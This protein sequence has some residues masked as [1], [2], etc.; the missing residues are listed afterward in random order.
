MVYKLRSK[1]VPLSFNVQL[2]AKKGLFVIKKTNNG[3]SMQN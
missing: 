2:M 3:H 1:L